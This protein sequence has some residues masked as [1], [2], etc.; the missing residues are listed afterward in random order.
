[1]A[2]GEHALIIQNKGG[3][4]GEI[5]YHLALT[6]AK[7]KKMKVTVLNDKYSDSK[8]PFK[9]HLLD[10]DS[11]SPGPPPF[12]PPADLFMS[13]ALFVQQNYGDLTAAG[14]EVIPADL[15][16]ADVASL[17]VRACYASHLSILI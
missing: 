3:G 9:V 15:A 2:A 11:C 1:M 14:V 6:L 10:I 17:L 5:G 16:T 13:S 7:D 8:L 4:H 12:E